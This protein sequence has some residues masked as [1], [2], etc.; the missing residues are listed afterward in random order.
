MRKELEEYS[1]EATTLIVAQR[2]G[3]VKK[4]DKIIVLDEGKMVGCGTH[5]ELLK[6]CKVYQE[7]ALSQLSKEELENGKTNKTSKTR[8][9]GTNAWICRKSKRF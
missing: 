9:N 3:T 2:L 6:T 8:R 7:I 5:E 4:A 1:K